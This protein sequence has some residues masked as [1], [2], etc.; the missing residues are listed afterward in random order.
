MAFITCSNAKALQALP[1]F[2]WHASLNVTKKWMHP[3]LVSAPLGN[4]STG[5]AGVCLA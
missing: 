2:I 4:S 1:L 5:H 3:L